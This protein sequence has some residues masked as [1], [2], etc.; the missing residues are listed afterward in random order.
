MSSRTFG[1]IQNPGELKT[2]RKISLCLCKG[3]V[4]NKWL[5]EERLPLLLKND[6]I[7]KDNFDDFI[8]IINSGKYPYVKLK[9]RDKNVEY[10]NFGIIHYG[11]Y[12]EYDS[13]SPIILY[14][15]FGMCLS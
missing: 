9:G 2:L 8:V 12:A 13:I 10:R 14:S 15:L 5:L 1:W 3:T 4:E 11:L 6:M 7:S